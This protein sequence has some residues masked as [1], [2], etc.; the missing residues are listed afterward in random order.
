MVEREY[1]LLIAMA[2]MEA[3]A[4]RSRKQAAYAEQQEIMEET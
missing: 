2:R 3:D 1:G 4:A